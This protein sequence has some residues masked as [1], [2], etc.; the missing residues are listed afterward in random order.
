M[1]ETVIC[2]FNRGLHFRSFQNDRRGGAAFSQEELESCMVNQP[3]GAPNLSV[4]SFTGAFHGRTMGLSML[5]V[6][7]ENHIDF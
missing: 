4:L 6:Y 1:K 3:P 2:I 7:L 5:S